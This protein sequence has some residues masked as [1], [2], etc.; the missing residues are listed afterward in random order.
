MNTLIQAGQHLERELAPEPIAGPAAGS[1]LLHGALAAGLLTY[2]LL[3]GLFHHNVWGAPGSGGAI[4]VTLVTHAL[5]LPSDQP[6]NDN[7]L[8]TETPS[9]AAAEPEVKSKAAIDESALA[10]KGKQKKSEQ[11]AVKSI[12]HPAEPE[13]ENLARYGE[14]DGSSTPRAT[15]PQGFTSGSTTVSDGDFG[16]RFPWYVDGINRK[17]GSVFYRPEVDSRTP[18]GA[19]AFVQ[20]SIDREG[21]VSNAQIN[22]QSGSTT[23]DRSCLRAA[24]R[25]DTFGSLPAQYSQNT[26]MTLYYC[27]Y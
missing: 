2:G 4:Q 17:M 3:G 8:A 27:E 16:S 21:R 12:K 19:R 7:V 22:Q 10:I 14:Q 15:Q 9:K 25:V 23:L 1:L 24:Q 6:V 11:K 18:K 20:F 26:V 5:P 13:Q